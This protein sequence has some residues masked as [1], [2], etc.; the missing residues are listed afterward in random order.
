MPDW[1]VKV[2]FSDF[3]SRYLHL[4][5]PAQSAEQLERVVRHLLRFE[6]ID[7]RAVRLEGIGVSGLMNL[8]GGTGGCPASV[9]AGVGP[10]MLDSPRPLHTPA[11]PCSPSQSP[12][13]SA[14]K[15]HDAEV[16]PSSGTAPSKKIRRAF[17]HLEKPKEKAARR[18]P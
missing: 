18:P 12:W 15:A 6:R 7:G 5:A 13:S 11:K 4:P 10:G 17:L 8:N 1:V 16:P 3:A 14:H 9:H 2:K